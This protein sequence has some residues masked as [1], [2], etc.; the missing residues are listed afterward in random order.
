MWILIVLGV[1][2]IFAFVFM[3]WT[4]CAAGPKDSLDYQL[5][6]LKQ[7]YAKQQRNKTRVKV[8]NNFYS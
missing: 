1:I 6:C 5:E 8:D 2:V 7:E 3:I 4:L